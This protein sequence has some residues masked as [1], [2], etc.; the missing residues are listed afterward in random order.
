[1]HSFQEPTRH[2]TR[3]TTF[4]IECGVLCH[5]LFANG[6]R[7]VVVVAGGEEAE[8]FLKGPHAVLL[9][10]SGAGTS[11]R[12]YDGAARFSGTLHERRDARDAARRG[13]LPSPPPSP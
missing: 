1:M 2:D 3:N 12:R 11:R 13:A 9:A 7:L 4:A 5:V 8:A 6:P 10:G